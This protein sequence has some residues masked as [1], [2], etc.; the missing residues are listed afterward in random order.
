MSAKK[1]NHSLPPPRKRLIS[2]TMMWKKFILGT[3]GEAAVDRM[4]EHCPQEDPNSK[5]SNRFP[6]AVSYN[7]SF[8]KYKLIYFN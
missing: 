5:S 8:L 6:K 1:Q 3:H 2:S 4:N 7:S